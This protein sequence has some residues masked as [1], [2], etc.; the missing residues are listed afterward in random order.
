MQS[1]VQARGLVE[2]PNGRRNPFPLERVAIP[3]DLSYT[4]NEFDLIRRGM[5]LDF[6]QQWGIY[7]EEPWMYL[8]RGLQEVCMY[9]I[10]FEQRDQM[11]VV[12][13]A[14]LNANP[15]QD[16]KN[17]VY[18]FVPPEN[19]HLNIEVIFHILMHRDDDVR[20]PG[21]LL[22]EY[23]AAGKAGGLSTGADGWKCSTVPYSVERATQLN[24]MDTRRLL[25]AIA[26][27][28]IGSSYESL[29]E[30]KFEFPLFTEWSKFTD[31]TVM[32]C[33]IADAVLLEEPYAQAMR[34][35]GK[36][37]PM[38]GYGQGFERWIF[39]DT[40]GAYGSSGNG[41]AMRVAAIGLSCTSIEEVLRKAKESAE[42]THNHPE[43][44]QGAQAVA[45][46]AW[47]ARNKAAKSEIRSEITTRIGY[48][49]TRTLNDIRPGYGWSASC[50]DSVPESILCFL[51]AENYEHAIRNA[52]SLGGDADTMA[53]MAGAIA[54]AY[55]DGVPVEIAEKVLPL[56]SVDILDTLNHFSARYI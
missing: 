54:A 36:R 25:G 55:W 4:T 42:C 2:R 33:A 43:G 16:P 18:F 40:M 22:Q 34:R 31:D 32:T 10:R 29:G 37:Y 53:A 49:L 51:E 6:D 44:I 41:S 5:A 56:L 35:W 27:D 21:E 20:V 26:G 28:V 45:L 1:I 13:E 12:A 23:E 8:T 14:Y 39:D 48:D 15:H 3:L 52:I 7:Y 38:A 50:K 24:G 47:L 9:A 30:K 17:H 11:F 46:A 19:H